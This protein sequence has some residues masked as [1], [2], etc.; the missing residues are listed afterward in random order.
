MARSQHSF[1]KRQREKDRQKKNKEKRERMEERK[2]QRAEGGGGGIEIDWSLAP[3]NLTL[4]D[5]EEKAKTS[6]EDEYGVTDDESTPENDEEE[7]ED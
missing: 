7:N 1:S 6:L 3:E 5:K 2:Q 4:N